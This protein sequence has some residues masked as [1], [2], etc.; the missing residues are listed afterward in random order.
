MVD[1]KI[2]EGAKCYRGRIPDDLGH[3]APHRINHDSADVRYCCEPLALFYVNSKGHL[4]PIAI[5]LHQKHGR[6]N[7]IWTPN[8]ANKHDWMLAKLWVRLADSNVHQVIN[9]V[10]NIE[11][12]DSVI[13]GLAS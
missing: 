3:S 9:N 1:Y 2:L 5:Q 12:D 13:E 8:E 4:M 6:A 10:Y 7:P 11:D